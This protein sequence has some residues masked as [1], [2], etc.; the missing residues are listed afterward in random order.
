VNKQIKITTIPGMS[1]NEP[2]FLLTY[3]WI[4]L[5]CCLL[6]CY[7]ANPKEESYWIFAVLTLPLVLS[8]TGIIR[9]H[10]RELAIQIGISFS[11]M[12]AFFTGWAPPMIV[13]IF[14][15]TGILSMVFLLRP[16]G[17][18][19]FVSM[20]M[21]VTVPI[22]ISMMG[23]GENNFH[24]YYSKLAILIATAAMIGANGY[25]IA[26]QNKWTINETLRAQNLLA[27]MQEV[28]NKF[29]HVISK[30]PNLREAL[31]EVTDL[32]IP[33]LN[34]QDCVIYILDPQFN[35]LEQVAA[36]GP[37]SLS[38][39]EILSPLKIEIGKGVVGRVAKTGQ[40]ILLNDTSKFD[41]YIT[42]DSRRLSELAVPI[43]FEGSVFGVID[44]E[45]AEKS[46]FTEDHLVLF[47]MIATLCAN[48]I[49]ELRLIKSEVE[50][51]QAEK[52]LHQI[53]EVENLRNSFLNNLS[54]DLR[55]PLSLIRGPLQ[56]LAKNENTE[57]RKLSDIALRNAARLNEMVSGLLD[58]HSLERGALI[59]VM[60]RAD[61]EPKFR[62]WYSLF[63]HE[64][65]KRNIK[66]LL[67]T[68]AVGIA[69]T[70]IYKLSQIVQNLLSN[71]F[72]FTPDEG[73]IIFNSS[74]QNDVLVL[75]VEDSGPGIKNEERLNVFERFYKIDHDSHHAGTG[76]GLAM[77]KEF[78]ELL[79]GTAHVEDGSLNGARL[80]VQ[81]PIIEYEPAEPQSLSI[82][83]IAI[84]EKPEIVVVEDHPEMNAFIADLL[85]NEYTVHTA[86]NAEDGWK[87]INHVV[88]DLVIT[89]L[90][91][92]GMSGE[93]LCKRIKTTVSTDHLP[94]L[95]LSAKQSADAKITLYKY[96]ADNYLTKPFD[97]DELR[98]VVASLIN[99]RNKL[100]LKFSGNIA[101]SHSSAGEGMRKIDITITENIANSNF[102]PLQLGS[103]LG[104]GRNQLQRK[105][106][107]VTGYT[108]VEYIRLLRLENARK[109]LMRGEVTVSEAAFASGF[110]Q[111]SYFSKAYKVH[112]NVSPSEDLIKL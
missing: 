48:K 94:V 71:A 33:A 18:F 104:I 62:E 105:I 32:C 38:R 111:V 12:T 72:K 81:I 85:S 92:P 37:K 89:D 112:F 56:E 57:V 78:S 98:S 25:T 69:F 63:L 31:W 50:K 99:Q 42:D 28:H 101:K 29:T 21:L 107:S 83:A 51:A 35:Y 49:A 4:I 96:G 97:S 46:F 74:V 8:Y 80:V 88:P 73:T 14:V 108:P 84:S 30:A 60:S 10:W 52:E 75:S 79:G 20:A 22:A 102:G 82:N 34:L 13:L 55:T 17:G 90:M 11:V 77:V 16:W 47:Q 6:T 45:H 103:I 53:N 109:M 43:I 3:N 95:A 23:F 61:L 54:H 58:M 59:P 76:L 41:G 40:A 1:K 2:L 91:L 26:K 7:F 93:M 106:K 36:Y 70:D 65:E 64:A 39:R 15:A 86:F 44:S 5:F 100:Q 27:Q 66:Y 67:E 9:G 87:I 110:N 19:Y 24:S 68:C